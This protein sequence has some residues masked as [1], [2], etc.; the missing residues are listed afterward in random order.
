M[1]KSGIED[2]NGVA[3]GRLHIFQHQGNLRVSG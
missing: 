1:I 3:T 2:M